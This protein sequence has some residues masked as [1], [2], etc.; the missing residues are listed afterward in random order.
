MYLFE[1]CGFRQ[2]EL[3]LHICSNINICMEPIENQNVR[4]QTKI[5]SMTWK[6]IMSH[7]IRITAVGEAIENNV[8][9]DAKGVLLVDV[10]LHDTVKHWPEWSCLSEESK[11]LSKRV[12][13]YC[14]TMPPYSWSPWQRC[15]S[16]DI[17]GSFYNIQCIVLNCLFGSLVDNYSG[18][19]LHR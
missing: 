3:P 13:S 15:S 7:K 6:H 16:S 19:N 14:T 5:Y 8:F 18:N 17:A 2:L 11:T 4:N 10:I 12:L 1:K 9:W